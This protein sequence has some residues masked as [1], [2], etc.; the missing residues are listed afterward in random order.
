MGE[1]ISLLTELKDREARLWYVPVDTS[2]RVLPRS[3]SRIA[4]ASE[5]FNGSRA[6]RHDVIDDPEDAT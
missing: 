6:M 3:L 2:L 1:D 5:H 4:R